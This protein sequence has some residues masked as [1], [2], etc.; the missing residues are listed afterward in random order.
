MWRCLG[1]LILCP[2]RVFSYFYLSQGGYIFTHSHFWVVC[3]SAGIQKDYQMDFNA[4]FSLT[5]LWLLVTF[6]NPAKAEVSAV[7]RGVRHLIIWSD[8]RLVHLKPPLSED[9]GL[10]ISYVRRS[11]GFFP[12][13]L[14]VTFHGKQANQQQREKWHFTISPSEPFGCHLAVWWV[15]Q[16]T[17]ALTR[18]RYR[19]LSCYVNVPKDPVFPHTL[20]ASRY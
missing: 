20:T 11:P 8:D 15:D 4:I 19:S 13:I 18:W 14:L 17:F 7:W 3:L 12:D 5:Q 10:A 1:L 6:Y 9:L 16:I 2:P